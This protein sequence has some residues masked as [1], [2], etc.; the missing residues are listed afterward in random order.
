M[1]DFLETC[2]KCWLQMGC[3]CYAAGKEFGQFVRSCVFDSQA[4]P[5]L[6]WLC[7]PVTIA[8][9]RQRWLEGMLKVF[10]GMVALPAP[11]V[12]GQSVIYNTLS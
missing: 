5:S 6:V 9:H 10:H 8:P 12:Q 3:R 7:P 2:T 1:K 11:G 4:Q